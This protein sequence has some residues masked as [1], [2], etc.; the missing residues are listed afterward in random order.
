MLDEIINYVQS[1]QRQ[2]EV[3]I[4]K[5]RRTCKNILILFVYFREAVLIDEARYGEPG[6][7]SGHAATAVSRR[8]CNENRLTKKPSLTRFPSPADVTASSWT[9]I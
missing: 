8:E 5:L 6:T 2:V 4:L 3:P 9:S 1:L 7:E